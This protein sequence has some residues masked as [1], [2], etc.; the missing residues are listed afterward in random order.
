MSDADIKFRLIISCCNAKFSKTTTQW[1]SETPAVGQECS[2][3][4]SGKEWEV[5][6][7]NVVAGS[8]PEG[9]IIF[10]FDSHNHDLYRFLYKSSLS[11]GEWKEIDEIPDVHPTA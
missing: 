10:L 5:M 8:E 11:G 2:I 1:L 6:C 3:E 9:V 7:S 4:L